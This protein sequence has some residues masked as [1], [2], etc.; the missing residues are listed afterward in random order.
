M[1]PYAPRVYCS[2]AKRSAEGSPEQR[3]RNWRLKEVAER[4]NALT[5]DVRNMFGIIAHFESRL[6]PLST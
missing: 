5:A 1:K 4:L 3:M 6:R 2:I